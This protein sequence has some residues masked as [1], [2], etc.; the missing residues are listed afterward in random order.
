MPCTPSF[1]FSE[2]PNSFKYFFCRPS[3]KRIH[4]SDLKNYVEL[5]YQPVETA[6]YGWNDVIQLLLTFGA[7]INIGLKRTFNSYCDSSER[8]TVLDWVEFAINNVK[9]NVAKL[10]RRASKVGKK[11]GSKSPWKTFLRTFKEKRIDTASAEKKKREDEEQK[12][13]KLKSSKA[14]KEYLE[15]V[16]RLLKARDAKPWKKVYPDVESTAN[17]KAEE[18]QNDDD[19]EEEEKID[20]SSYAFISSN[21]Q[22]RLVPRHLISRYNELYDACY[23]GD[24]AKVQKLCLP[25]ESD[26]GKDPALNIS[27]CVIDE[28]HRYGSLGELS[29]I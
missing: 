22:R 5:A 10:E 14:V 26:K 1:P 11:G 27:V 28:T 24:D 25:S 8:R 3:S 6:L 23:A 9:R 17:P 2:S 15:E 7:P 21:Y 29:Y 12:Q 13:M 20:D 16:L 18:T 19:E 4:D